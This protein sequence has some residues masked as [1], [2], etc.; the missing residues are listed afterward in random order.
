M[1]TAGTLIQQHR[2]CR[3][4]V[5]MEGRHEMCCNNVAKEAKRD[6]AKS[7]AD[8]RSDPLQDKTC[9]YSSSTHCKTCKS[10]R[11]LKIEQNNVFTKKTNEEIVTDLG[12]DEKNCTRNAAESGRRTHESEGRTEGRMMTLSISCSS[13]RQIHC[14][15]SRFRG[16]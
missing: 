8:N 11:T 15:M 10:D 2:K 13:L 14:K 6:T 7:F 12:R 1:K 9:S 5:R 3:R 16:T 4:S